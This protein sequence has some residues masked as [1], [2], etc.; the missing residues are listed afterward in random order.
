MPKITDKP[1]EAIQVRLFKEDLNALRRLYSGT[2]G[3]NKAI[4]TIIHTF[5]TQTQ[6]KANA[7]IDAQENMTHEELTLC[8]VHSM[9]TTYVTHARTP[10]E[11]KAEVVSDLNRR[12][13]VPQ[14][15]NEHHRP[16]RSGASSHSAGYQ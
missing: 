14:R 3:V 11:L 8:W 12:I 9:P 16:Q 2:F 5:V 6:A 10:Q 4:R 1:L 13:G 15:P 7:A